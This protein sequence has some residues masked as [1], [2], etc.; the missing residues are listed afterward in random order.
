MKIRN[1]LLNI[2][3]KL[4]RNLT[5][6]YYKK[7]K[8][9]EYVDLEE[10]LKYQETKLKEILL[11]SWK[12]VPYYTKILKKARIIEN[13]K[14]NL[15]N[16]NKIPI[17]TKEII[18]KER[19]KLLSNDIKNIRYAPNTSGGSTGE[20]VKFIQDKE[21]AS[22]DL[23]IV[24]IQNSFVFDYP[25]K[26]LKLWGSE[27]DIF[28]KW[29]VIGRTKDWLQSIKILNSFSMGEEDMNKYIKEINKYKPELIEAY[30]QSIYE[31]AKFIKKN[32]MEVFSPK[33]IITSAGTL[34]PEM[35]ELIEE[36][37]KT[38]VFNRYGSR[39]APTLACSC[40][41]NNELHENIF[42]RY[43][44]I[45]DKNLKPCKPGQVGDVYVTTLNNYSMPLIRYKIGDMAVP[46]KL[47]K[48]PCGRGMPLIEK[49]VGRTV[50][51]FKTKKGELID[52]LYFNTTIW[53]RK[54]AHSYQ[55]IQ[56]DYN[57]VLYKIKINEKP[58]ESE[59]KEVENLVKKVM[60][61]GCKVKFEFVKE[62]KPTKSG[63][64]LYTI[65]KIK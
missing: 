50:N 11:Y 35:R 40:K 16:F 18:R 59:L 19:D 2:A 15:K 39:E 27:R 32:K 34:Y 7:L 49:V 14:V 10:N 4:N 24:W 21:A 22:E 13:S 60:G 25:C 61:D 57:L 17:L 45:L 52:G 58:E 23:A 6:F 51:L 43:I 33:G 38:K 55:I 20:P 42:T 28:K 47:K 31:L 8:K 3:F 9:I 30:V 48:C 56:E 64:Y 62:I 37:F 26:H 63:K 12:N 54:W 41:K 36:V 65:S 29:D 46:S 44:E 53:K 5:F 1:L